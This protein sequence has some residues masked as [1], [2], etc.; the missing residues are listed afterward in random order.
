[1]LANAAGGIH[2]SRDNTRGDTAAG[3]GRGGVPQL[4]QLAM[5]S[6]GNPQGEADFA[7]L[8]RMVMG[9]PNDPEHYPR[10]PR[11]D[12]LMRGE[13]PGVNASPLDRAYYLMRQRR[14]R[15]NVPYGSTP[16]DRPA[17]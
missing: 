15:A 7:Q 5:S 12:L 11:A 6:V 9:D 1:M 3:I 2:V 4:Q 13:D 17:Y 10:S 16:Y 14:P 8:E